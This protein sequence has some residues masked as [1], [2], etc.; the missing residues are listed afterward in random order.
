MS[1]HKIG[2]C[3]SL[4]DARCFEIMGVWEAHEVRAGE[5]KRLGA[6]NDGTTRVS[7]LLL[8]GGYTDMTFC[9]DCADS[10]SPEQ[11]TLLWRKNLAGYMREQNGNPAKFIDQ[12]SNGLLCE[13]GR[14]QLKE[15][16]HG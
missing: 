15:L 4:C 13:L 9:G 1:P 14:Q 8:A 12:F 5:P 7:F 3:C 11:Y 16:A 6:A 2:G 10:L